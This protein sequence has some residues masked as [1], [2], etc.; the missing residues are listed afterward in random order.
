MKGDV[1]GSRQQVIKSGQFDF[2]LLDKVTVRERL[3]RQH[4]H[5]QAYGAGGNR[6]PDAAQP[7][8]SKRR[9]HDSR[10]GRS[11][12]ASFADHA[13]EPR[14][15]AGHGHQHCDGVFGYGVMVDAGRYS[16][17]YSRPVA[18]SDVD[19]IEADSRAGNDAQLARRFNHPGGIG[20][21]TGD[22][23][24]AIRQ[25]RNQRFLVEA[26]DVR[27]PMHQLEA[28]GLENRNVRPGIRIERVTQDFGLRR[29]GSTVANGA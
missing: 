14:K 20:L 15:A 26:I 11:R 25:V 28:V 7:H 3:V 2:P 18:G 6:A 24:L 21:G 10:E 9:P 27:R 4:V 16:N 13:V 8:N 23:R 5:S 29:H 22:A 1:V 12:P 19:G 17:R